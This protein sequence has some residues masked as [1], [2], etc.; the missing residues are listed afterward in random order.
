MALKFVVERI[1]QFSC[2]AL[3][4]SRIDMFALRP[5]MLSENMVVFFHL[6]K[7]IKK[8]YTRFFLHHFHLCSFKYIIQ[9][10]PIIERHAT[11]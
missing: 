10:H 11:V 9:N 4:S 5:V 1:D 6:F 3:Q 2:L 7:E 8:K